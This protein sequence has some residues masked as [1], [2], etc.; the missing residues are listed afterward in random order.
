MIV[1]ERLKQPQQLV[2]GKLFPMNLR[3]FTMVSYGLF[4]HGDSLLVFQLQRTLRTNFP[5]DC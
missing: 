1:V 2:V 5:T 3:T 4:Q